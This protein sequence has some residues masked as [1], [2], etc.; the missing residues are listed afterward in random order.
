LK[1]VGGD[2]GMVGWKGSVFV[3]RSYALREVALSRPGL[4]DRLEEAGPLSCV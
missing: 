2:G 4:S 1:T 3:S